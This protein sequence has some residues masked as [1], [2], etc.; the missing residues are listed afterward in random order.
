METILQID[1]EPKQHARP[2]ASPQASLEVPPTEAD[3]AEGEMRDPMSPVYS[4]PS[5]ETLVG[6]PTPP[7]LDYYPD[8]QDTH[9]TQEFVREH[10]T[11]QKLKSGHNLGD[12]DSEEVLE[13]E[14]PNEVSPGSATTSLDGTQ[15]AQPVVQPLGPGDAP[16]P[17]GGTDQKP[18][19]EN[20]SKPPHE[21]ASGEP[22]EHVPDIKDAQAPRPVLGQPHISEEAIRQRAKRIFMPRRDGSLKVSQEI[23]KE[24]KAKGKERK[25]LEEIFKRC[26]Y[27]AETWTKAYCTVITHLDCFMYHAYENI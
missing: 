20:K 27:N 16:A 4:L 2:V 3:G 21:I 24:W 26:G 22:F 7:S 23:F 14:S 6:S 25:N 13:V 19:H 1:D 10:G 11:F 18:P 5:S 15:Q 8:R 17:Y 9:D 12:L